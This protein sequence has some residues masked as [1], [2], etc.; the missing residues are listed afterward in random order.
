[1]FSENGIFILETLMRVQIPDV[2]NDALTAYCSRGGQ[3]GKPQTENR[4]TTNGGVINPPTMAK[5]CCK[6]MRIAK[7]MGIGSSMNGRRWS[8]EHKGGSE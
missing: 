7:K 6:P 2:I 4:K 5:Q 8:I 1:M 3:N